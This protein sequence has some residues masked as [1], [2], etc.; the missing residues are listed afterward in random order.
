MVNQHINR[1]LSHSVVFSTEVASGEAYLFLTVDQPLLTSN[2]INEILSSG[3][4]RNIV[5]P[6]KQ[7]KPCSPTFFG[8]E[9]RT[10][11]LHV[12]GQTGGS[13]IRDLYTFAHIKIPVE[14]ETQLLDIDT[15]EDYSILRGIL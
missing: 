7:G 2:L 9:F 4:T 6:M 3:N 13:S 11:L 14:N 8:R 5:F 12:K 10:D 1:G 15:L